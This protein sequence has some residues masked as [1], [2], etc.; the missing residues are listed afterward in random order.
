M[1]SAGSTTKIWVLDHNFNLWG[2]AIGELSNPA[3]Y[4]YID[5]V[6]WHGYAGDATGMSKVHDAFPEKSAYFTEGGP[7]RDPDAARVPG[8]NPQMGWAHWS[9]WANGVF[10]NWARSLTVWNMVLDENGTPYIGHPDPDD[11]PLGPSTGIITVESGTHKITRNSRFWAIAHYSKH[12]RRG[13]KVFRTDGVAEIPAQPS[14][15][16]PSAEQPT[17]GGVSHVGFRNPDGSMVVVLTN[18]G[19]ERQIQLMLGSSALEV[20]LP[21]DSVLTLQ[22][23]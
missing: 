18:G 23:S 10:R 14:S 11:P 20:E 17:T 7:L 21:A 6:A 12:V 4:Q 1:R 22:W 15:A 5:G 13:A 3:A 16:Q 2:R 19:E 9:A 8:S